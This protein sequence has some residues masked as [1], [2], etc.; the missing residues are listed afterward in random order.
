MRIYFK[1]YQG[2]GNDFIIINSTTSKIELTQ[3]QIAQLCNRRFGIG[4]DGFIIIENADDYDF[5]MRYFNSDGVEA[6]MCGNGGRC[7]VKFANE[8]GIAS[9][10]MKFLAADGEH[11]GEIVDDSVVISMRDVVSIK[12]FDDGYFLDTGSP[13]FVKI[14]DNISEID[15][16]DE[17]LRISN[18]NRFAP[19]RTNVNFVNISN[20]EIR[21]AT[22]ERGVE[23][24]TLACGTG[25]VASAIA[26]Y[27]ANVLV[28]TPIRIIAKG[29]LLEV[30]FEQQNTEYKN[31]TLK[32]LAKFVF[33]GNYEIL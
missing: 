29:G 24:E 5:F 6:T 30:E 14:V 26:L 18:E 33:E 12:K 13:H 10:K 19:Q 16:A 7:A 21:I 11:Y 27:K 17:G 28:N 22:F 2:T 1:K 31:I 8:N 15:V 25:A 23:D 9:S 32:G 4:A 3:Q 20:D